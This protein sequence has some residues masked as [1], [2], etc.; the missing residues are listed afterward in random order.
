M[1]FMASLCKKQL[2][3]GRLKHNFLIF[4]FGHTSALKVVKSTHALIV[5]TL[6]K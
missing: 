4:I 6:L 5:L 1:I 2:A 3:L